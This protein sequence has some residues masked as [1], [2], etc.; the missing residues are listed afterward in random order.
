MT[1][2]DHE[3]NALEP[4]AS[5][6]AGVYQVVASLYLEPPSSVLIAALLELAVSPAMAALSNGA[7]GDL[8]R[9]YAAGYH[10]EINELQQEFHDLFTVPLGRYVTPYEA[11]YRDERLVGEER[12]RGLLM[13]PS[14]VAVLQAYRDSGFA[15]SPQCKELPD[16]IG[17]E[18]SFLSSL[19]DRERQRWEARDA[20]AARLFLTHELRFLEDHLLRWVPEL[21]RRTAANARTLFF[22]GIA[23]LTEEFIQAD[24]AT[25]SGVL[26]AHGI[27]PSMNSRRAMCHTQYAGGR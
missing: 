11:V 25:L 6:R 10:G 7:A 2:Q 19:C 3:L 13:G 17:V 21:A 16:H 20:P 1:P 22:Q 23:C 12:V 24:A 4:F 14:T 18:L 9:R 5:A 27:P 8:L 26:S 15:V